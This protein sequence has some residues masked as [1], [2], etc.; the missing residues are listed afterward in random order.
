MLERFSGPG[1][2]FSA[3]AGDVS[4]QPGGDVLWWIAKPGTLPN[5][6]PEP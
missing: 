3:Q 1:L 6:L 5:L 4:L 2:Q